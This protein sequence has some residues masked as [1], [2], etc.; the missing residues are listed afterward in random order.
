MKNKQDRF[1][2]ENF[3]HASEDACTAAN[4]LVECLKGYDANNISEMLKKMH[5]YEHAGDTKKHEMSA[6]LAKA[7]VTPIDREDLALISQNIDDVTDR[8]E[9][10]LQCFYTYQITVSIVRF[11]NVRFSNPP[12]T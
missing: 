5:H 6:A 7:F 1:Y 12:S 3:V 10:I 8:I 4:Y 11:L 2:F 9:E